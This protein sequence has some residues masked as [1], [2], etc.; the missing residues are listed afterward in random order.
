MFHN[1][2]AVLALSKVGDRLLERLG[3]PESQREPA[4]VG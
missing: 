2:Q 3:A 4:N 1:S